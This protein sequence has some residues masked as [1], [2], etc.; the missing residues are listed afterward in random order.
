MDLSNICVAGFTG[1]FELAEARFRAWHSK[2]LEPELTRRLDEAAWPQGF[3]AA[4]QAFYRTH[5]YR[6]LLEREC[7]R[8]ICFYA[9]V[10]RERQIRPYCQSFLW[11][12]SKTAS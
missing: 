3:G 12:S 8:R 10:T 2:K 5:V 6:E 11:Q 7:R 9:D 4:E 1:A